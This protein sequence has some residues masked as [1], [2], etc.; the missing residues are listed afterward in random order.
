MYFQSVLARLL[1]R[2]FGLTLSMIFLRAQQRGDIGSCQRDGPV[3]L[4]EIGDADRFSPLIIISPTQCL[5]VFMMG[6][7]HALMIHWD[8]DMSC[9]ERFLV[10]FPVVQNCSLAEQM[11]S[12]ALNVLRCII[13]QYPVGKELLHSK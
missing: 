7:A 11:E 8:L 3:P 10:Q 2:C 12:W 6:K 1:Q 5:V 13:V 4:G 9:T